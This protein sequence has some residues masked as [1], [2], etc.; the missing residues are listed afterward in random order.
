MN[1]YLKLLNFEFNR[2]IKVYLSLISITIIMQVTGVFVVSN[3]YLKDAH[4]G[5][6]EEGMSMNDFIAW[7]G[8]M[9]MFKVIR[10]VWFMGPIALCASALIIYMFLIWYR[11]WFG[12]NTFIYRLLMLP[13]ERLNVFFAKAT[14]IMI[15]VIG[16][17]AVQLILLPIES[18]ILKLIVPLEYRVDLTV[19]GIIRNYEK[20]QAILPLTFTDFLL[21]YGIGLL[22]MTV[23]FTIILLERSYRLK[24]IFI[25]V[26]Y[27]VSTV[28]VF[29]S[30][31]LIQNILNKPLF[32]SLELLV[33][34]IVLGVLI[35]TGSIWCSQF[36]LRKKVSV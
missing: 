14:A 24:G 9:D 12:K 11:D 31:L 32:H 23:L 6:Y 29:I 3:Q 20:L 22:V 17:V 30:P 18:Y 13:T 16:L 26:L 28:L 36:L 5:I 8:T 34:E 27:G 21:Y 10:S 19:S 25:G 2:F 35:I 33:I 15:M 7:N 4:I 1:R